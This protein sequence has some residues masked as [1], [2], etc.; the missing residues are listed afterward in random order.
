M[1]GGLQIKDTTKFAHAQVKAGASK[2][3]MVKMVGNGR[4]P[5]DDTRG[6]TGLASLHNNSSSWASSSGTVL[7]EQAKSMFNLGKTI[8]PS[9]LQRKI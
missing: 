7:T 4:Q 6:D 5:K 8:P 1:K 3:C 9:T 2:G